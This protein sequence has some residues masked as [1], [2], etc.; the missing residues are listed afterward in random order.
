MNRFKQMPAHSLDQLHLLP[1]TDIGGHLFKVNYFMPININCEVYQVYPV[2][3]PLRSRITDNRDNHT[4]IDNGKLN[5]QQ[6]IE[7]KTEKDLSGL[8]DFYV[9]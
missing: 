7:A 6:M 1:I 3:L 4:C 2:I 9:L 8:G 5:H